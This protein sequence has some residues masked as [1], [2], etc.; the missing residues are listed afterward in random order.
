MTQNDDV[1]AS[2]VQDVRDLIRMKSY[3]LYELIWTLNTEHPELDRDQKLSNSM[4]ALRELVATNNLRIVK[5][6]WPSEDVVGE[7]ELSEI[8]PTDF[9]DPPED[10]P[11]TALMER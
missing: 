6:N 2:L 10:M 1:V 8:R 9:D 11:Y 7:L 3:G 4:A 5:L